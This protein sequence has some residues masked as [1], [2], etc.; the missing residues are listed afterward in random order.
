MDPF[1]D[2]WIQF[3]TNG[4]SSG[5]MDPVLKQMDPVLKQMD[6]VLKQMDPVLKQMDPFLDKRIQF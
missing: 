1:L 2:K 5:Q 4:S 3:W 6:P